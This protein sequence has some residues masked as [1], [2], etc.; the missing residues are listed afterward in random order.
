[1]QAINND[2]TP[3]RLSEQEGVDCDTRSY[4]CRGGWMHN[5]WIMSRDIGSQT[6]ADYPYEAQD[7]DCRN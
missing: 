6:N 1:M 3:V 5:Y 4:G 7:G 2:A